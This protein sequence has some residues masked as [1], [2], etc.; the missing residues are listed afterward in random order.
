M[1]KEKIEK[2]ALLIL[3]I[4][5]LVYAYN[6]YLFSPKLEVLQ[7]AKGLLIERQ[8][9]YNQLVSSKQNLTDIEKDIETISNEAKDLSAQI[10]PR[11]DNPQIMVDI[12]NSAKLY[13]V[14]PSTLQ[15]GQLQ[16]KGSY[17]ALELNF[18]CK[19]NVND[20]LNLI[21]AFQYTALQ[22]LSIQ[23]VTI[24][25][26]G[27]S[28]TT[29]SSQPTGYINKIVAKTLGDDFIANSASQLL[30]GIETEPFAA[31]S[32]TTPQG[33]VTAQIKMTV[34]ASSLGTADVNA[35][36]PSFM[37]AQFGVNSAA[38]MFK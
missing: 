36:N 4:M 20:V 19:G 13:G 6:T 15:F 21:T 18:T 24:T 30:Q 31:Y 26:Q 25:S 29:D 37:S 3:V 17:E 38:E 33:M 14:D 27:T 10:P 34:Y 11:L 35:P 5:G 1:N 12:Y 9:H 8:Q 32:S 28:S 16:N 23:S 22:K 2:I 7:K